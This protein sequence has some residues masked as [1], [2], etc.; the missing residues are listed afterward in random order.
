MFVTSY[1]TEYGVPKTGLSPKID[2]W[3]VSDNAQVVTQG[4]MVE[5]GGGFYKYDF[6][7]Y[8]PQLEYMIRCDGGE[9]LSTAER[10]TF[11]GNEGFHDDIDDIKTIVED[12]EILV[13]RVLGLSQENYRLFNTVYDG[14]GTK[15]IGCTIKLYASKTDCENDTNAIARYT[16]TASYDVNSQLNDYKVVKETT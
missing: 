12:I 8:S 14:S 1:F 7:T 13:R 11:A 15:L 2:I 6:A 4:D 3:R 5:I 10:F 9:T 16:M